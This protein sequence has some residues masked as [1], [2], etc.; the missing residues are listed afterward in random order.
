MPLKPNDSLRLRLQISRYQLSSSRVIHKLE[1]ALRWRRG[2]RVSDSLI[3]IA[4]RCISLPLVSHENTPLLWLA[5]MS[6]SSLILLVMS[7]KKVTTYDSGQKIGIICKN[8]Y[9]NLPFGLDPPP[10]TPGH[11][12]TFRAPLDCPASD[13]LYFMYKISTFISNTA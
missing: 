11:G 10:P 2:P 7:Q 13:F 3:P 9:I 5:P 6:S 12:T 4:P 1:I 8:I